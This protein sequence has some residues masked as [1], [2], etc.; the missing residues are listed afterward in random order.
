MSSLAS[1]LF[2]WTKGS[3]VAVN[4]NRR[5]ERDTSGEENSAREDADSDDEFIHFV[6]I[7]V[8]AR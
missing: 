4:E 1:S 2:T 8:D 6:F 5:E 3:Y 7:L